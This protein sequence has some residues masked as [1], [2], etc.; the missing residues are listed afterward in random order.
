MLAAIVVATALV[1][2]TRLELFSVLGACALSTTAN[3]VLFQSMLGAQPVETEPN[4]TYVSTLAF[5]P[6]I[7]VT[8]WLVLIALLDSS[9]ARSLAQ[10]GH[11]LVRRKTVPLSD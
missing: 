2:H 11:P 6:A 7:A 9:D 3:T 8:A 1:V 4:W 10:S 5:V